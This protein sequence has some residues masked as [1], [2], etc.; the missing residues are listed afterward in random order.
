MKQ[1]KIE[2]KSVRSVVFA[3]TIGGELLKLGKF[4]NPALALDKVEEIAR[5]GVV[6][7]FRRKK[8]ECVWACYESAPNEPFNLTE[9]CPSLS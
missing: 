3:K 5:R 4:R 8:V 7:L 1:K 9:L 6:G 2:R